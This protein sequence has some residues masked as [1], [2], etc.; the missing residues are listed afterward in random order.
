MPNHDLLATELADD[1]LA[2]IL[3]IETPTSVSDVLL[4]RSP[5]ILGRSAD[6][7]IVVL[8]PTVSRRHLEISQTAA[9]YQI[10][11]LNSKLGLTF[12]G[13]RI[14]EKILKN[15][16]VF[17]IGSN[18]KLTFTENTPLYLSQSINLKNKD[19]VTIGRSSDNDV[20]I[21]HPQ[22]SRHH[23]KIERQGTSLII[24]DLD[25]FNGTFLNGK[26][27]TRPQSLRAGDKLRI[28]PYLLQIKID[29]TIVVT[30]EAGKLRFDVINLEKT[31]ATN[32]K[33]LNNI[34]LSFLPR[35]FIVIAGV[36]G[37][38]KST[39]LKALIGFSPAT[40]GTI[41]INGENL[42]QD[43]DAYRSEFAYVPQ[44]DIVHTDL[45]VKQALDFAAQLR[46]PTDTTERERNQRVTDVMEEL[47]LTQHQESIIKSL[48][49]GQ[50]KRVSIGVELL[51]KPSLFFL[52]EA[53]SGLDPGT[54]A[55]VMR[56][57]RTLANEDGT[58]VLITHM[59][60][61]IKLCDLVVFL[62]AGGRVAYFGPP[63]QAPEYF[64]VSSFNAIYPLIERERSPEEWQQRYLN[65]K[66]YQTYVVSRQANIPPSAEPAD[67][68]S[69]KHAKGN[70]AKKTS[71]NRVS[72]WQQF[73]IFLQR[74]IAILQR[75][76]PT[77][78]L[79]FSMPFLI[80]ILDFVTW[81]RNL[82]DIKLGGAGLSITMLFI[83]ALVAVMVG[84]L[85]TM[86]AIS[87]EQEIYKRERLI[88][89]KVLPYVCSKLAFALILSLYQAF[90]FLVFK[91]LAITFPA[92]GWGMQAELY[93]TLVLASFSGMV[94]GLLVSAISPNQ[95]VAPLLVI[96]FVIPQV[97]FGG[98]IVSLP[99]L[100]AV[101]RWIN[102]ITVVKWPFEIFVTST[103]IGKD[104][105]N[106]P[107]WTEGANPQDADC[108]CTGA[109]LFQTCYFPGIRDYFVPE[110]NQ[111]APIQP[112]RP[113][114]PRDL[115]EISTFETKIEDYTDDINTW[116]KEYEQW[117]LKREQAIGKAEGILD[118]INR[119]FGSTFQVNLVRHWFVL[120]VLIGVMVGL[121]FWVQVQKSI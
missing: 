78:V 67:S 70:K 92:G 3:K 60:E 61:N 45:S 117:S 100:S 80:G 55:D 49:G 33:I 26:Q 57:L 107:C 27:L 31:V 36:S 108:P 97:T 120:S 10:K 2:P 51:T 112:V 62:A 13:E 23:A 74:D 93:L 42:Y 22:L 40:R 111:P 54:E 14:Q 96:L 81:N 115:A 66:Q 73:L 106:D 102:Y 89:L 72:S 48:S 32:K 52:D 43:F 16:D 46:M 5:M 17:Y 119:N 44:Q 114:F 38:G 68:H 1:E 95:A 25:S 91:N 63:E 29:E 90:A 6:S 77:F 41:L 8:Y 83:M 105:A 113:E 28:G 53:T 34:C 11:D 99:D 118:V 30:D 35:E 110:I 71:A 82:F 109:Q 94:M 19:I 79:N 59:T 116:Q 87:K 9:G 121:I 18:V 88:G 75:D 7:N 4:E 50:L 85:T 84:S 24:S 21:D 39:L 86:R 64:G 20:Q 103:G 98:G 58:V 37:C 47:G 15:G 104:L 65:S 69:Q 12:L 101:G 56:L 76:K